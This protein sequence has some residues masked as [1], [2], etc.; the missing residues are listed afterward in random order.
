MV[1]TAAAG[2]APTMPAG[3][4]TAKYTPGCSTQAAIMAMSATKLSS[5]IEP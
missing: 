2:V 1:A 3:E 4:F 5:T